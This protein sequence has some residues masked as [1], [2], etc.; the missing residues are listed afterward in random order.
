MK[1]TAI[2]PVSRIKYLDRVLESLTNQT[3]KPDS[4]VVVFDGSDNEFLQVRNKVV[5]LKFDKVLCV[6]STNQK[7]ASTIPERRIH[8]TNIH[9]QLRDLIGD[10]DWIF[11]LEDDSV[12]PPDALRKLAKFAKLNEDVGMVTGVEIGR[13]GVPYIGAWKVDNIDKPYQVTSMT[14]RVAEDCVE[15]IDACGLY[16]AL[17]RADYYKT[18]K[19]FTDNGLGPDVNLGLYL[20][21]QGFNNY[22]DWSIHVTHL[23]FRNGEEVEIPATDQSQPLTLHLLSG[24]TWQYNKSLT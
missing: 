5:E 1:I 22:I 8:I 10:C 18:H 3:Q 17:V 13:W 2:L 16:C 14:S 7:I 21:Q 4:L 24:T 15:G 9:N 20:R 23:T 6:P 12:L 11:S 19:F